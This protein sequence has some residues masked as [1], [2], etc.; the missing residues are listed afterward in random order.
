MGE[1]VAVVDLE[2]VVKNII[3]EVDDVSWGPNKRFR[4][5]KRGGTGAIWNGL[6]DL[7]GRHHIRLNSPVKHIDAVNKIAVIN[8]DFLIDYDY[9]FSTMPLD[10]L[11]SLT[12]DVSEST[13]NQAKSLRYSSANIVGIGLSGSPPDV[14]KK[15]SWMYFPE[16]NCPFYQ[17]TV[18]SN[19]SPYNV[20]D[21]SSQWSL[22]AEVSESSFKAVNHDTLIDEVIGGMRNT[23]LIGHDHSVITRWSY[24]APH[25]Y[26][27]PFLG[28][29]AVLRAIHSE[30]EAKNI[31][32]RGRFGGWK[33]EV[34][35]QD[36]SFMQGVEWVNFILSGEPEKT[37][38]TCGVGE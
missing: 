21:S 14:L 24:R 10:E 29:D 6:T 3:F 17:V 22:M 20:P 26:P 25:G 28:R 16:D 38:R 31:F 2:A 8:G 30:L 34:A 5:P 13:R 12:E 4:F 23:H 7:I 9:L 35:N 19:Y 27:M 18:F 11:V 36:H 33:Y 37:Y 15:K 1:R 32:S